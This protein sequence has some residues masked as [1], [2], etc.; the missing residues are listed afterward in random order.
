MRTAHTGRRSIP[1]C[2]TG[3]VYWVAI[4]LSSL[5]DVILSEWS[6]SFELLLAGFSL[7]F[8]FFALFALVL[9]HFCVSFFSLILVVVGIAMPIILRECRFQPFLPSNQCMWIYHSAFGEFE[10]VHTF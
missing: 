9:G 10:V 1:I 6:P 7:G 8:T 2:A 3:L 5:S 4:A